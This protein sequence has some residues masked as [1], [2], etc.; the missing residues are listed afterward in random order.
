HLQE[1]YQ[2]RLEDELNQLRQPRAMPQ[3]Q[4]RAQF[5]GPV[6]EAVKAGYVESDFAEL[7]PDFASQAM[8]HVYM[9]NDARRAIAELQKE[10]GEMTGKSRASE[11]RQRLDA[12]LDDLATS[13][14]NGIG[15]EV[16]SP[17]KEATEREGFFNFLLEL[18]P[19][20]EKLTPEFLGKQW[21]AFK[22]E[23]LLTA[24]SQAAGRG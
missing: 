23:A 11:G 14:L 2:A 18:N 15:A 9:L 10:L 4:I 1:K 22:H 13:G 6:Q 16:F 8:M 21:I 17:L 3:A 12:K 5:A 20:I 7:Y 24:A 19:P